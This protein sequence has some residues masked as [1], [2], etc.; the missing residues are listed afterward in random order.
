MGR[1]DRTPSSIA[2]RSSSSAS[3]LCKRIPLCQS[4][5]KVQVTAK[6]GSRP[7][8]LH[9]TNKEF[10]HSASTNDKRPKNVV[11]VTGGASF[12]RQK[13]CFVCSGLVQA[14]IEHV[15]RLASMVNAR[16]VTQFD[17]E[18]THVIVK[19]DDGN[20]GASKTLKYLQGIAHRKWILGAQ[21]VIDSLKAKKLINEERYEVV[22]CRTL[23]AGPR[24]SRLRERDLFAGFVFLC[25]GPYVDVSIEQYQVKFQNI[26]TA[27]GG[28]NASFVLFEKLDRPLPVGDL[29]LLNIL[30]SINATKKPHRQRIDV[31]IYVSK[32]FKLCSSS[33]RGLSQF[34]RY[35]QCL[36]I[37]VRVN[38]FLFAT[39]L[40]LNVQATL[41]KLFARTHIG[42]CM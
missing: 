27:S 20:N 38:I 8:E 15:K 41:S 24:N 22:D 6:N 10:K 9:P 4:T 30:C 3:P 7:A 36:H 34:G 17:P 18:V 39:Q 25:I 16:Y 14:Q 5:P 21:W 28:R 37:R 32:K 23:E 26:S 35:R 40:R 2:G 29:P 12:G 31:R 13:L 33:D 1:F 42:Y 11:S 19:T